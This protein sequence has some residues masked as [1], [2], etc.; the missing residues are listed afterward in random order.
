MHS[1]LAPTN[2]LGFL[3]SALAGADITTRAIGVCVWIGAIAGVL[4]AAWLVWTIF[5]GRRDPLTGLGLVFAVMVV[6]GPVVQPWY[7]LWAALPLAASALSR[8]ARTAVV[9][10]S[11]TVAMLLS[12][13][14]LVDVG[15]PGRADRQD[16]H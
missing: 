16:Q 10:T 4:V 11:A 13:A 9:A 7:V 5:V 15:D 3:A 14:S 8:R 12:A 1:W 2:Q 6:S